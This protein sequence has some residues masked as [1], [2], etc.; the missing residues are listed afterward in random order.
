M[1]VVK[2]EVWVDVVPVRMGVLV[3]AIY[4]D[5]CAMVVAV[6]NLSVMIWKSCLYT[7]RLWM[8]SPLQW[9]AAASS[10]FPDLL[11]ALKCL[12]IRKCQSLV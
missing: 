3:A 9:R 6:R 2:V 7:D 4:R 8:R 10:P 1:S 11:A 12:D 5:S